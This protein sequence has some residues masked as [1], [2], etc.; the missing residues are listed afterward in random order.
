MQLL[1]EYLPLAAFLVAY[2]LGGIYVATAT[3]MAGMALSLA[4]LW[5][6]AGRM[7]ALFALSTALVLVFG[8]ATLILRNAR[9]IQWKPSILLWLL[10]G[11]FLVSNFVGR[12]PLAQRLM[13]SALGDLRIAR[14]DWLSLNWAWV[15]FG[16]I[17]GTANI[18]VAYHASEATWVNTKVYGLI[19]ASFLFVAGQAIWLNARARTGA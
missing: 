8:A 5:L 12:E 14:R 2:K 17:T 19:G 7:P 16:L 15:L 10:A 13:Q 3:L 4:V 1:L 18:L 6:R 11:A 9:F